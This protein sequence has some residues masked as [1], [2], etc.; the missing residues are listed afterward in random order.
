M[1]KWMRPTARRFI[2][3]MSDNVVTKGLGILFTKDFVN[4]AKKVLPEVAVVNDAVERAGAFRND[5]QSKAADI[6]KAFKAL[7]DADQKTVNAVLEQATVFG[8]WPMGPKGK[9]RKEY[10]DKLSDTDRTNAERVA[11][12]Y[13]SL[14]MEA[15]LVVDSVLHHGEE[16]KETMHEEIKRAGK[17]RHDEQMAR[18]YDPEKRKELEQTFKLQ[19][20]KVDKDFERMKGPYV[21]LKRFGR[22]VVT[23][24]SKAYREKAKFAEQVRDRLR[25]KYPNPTPAQLVPYHRLL[26]ELDAMR[27][28]SDDYIVET[29][30]TLGQA[31]ERARELQEL[32]PE[33]AVAAFAAAEHLNASVPSW[34]KLQQ[35]ALSVEHELESDPAQPGRAEAINQLYRAAN[36]MY[37]TALAN[38]SAKKAMLRRKTV[39]GWNSNMMENFKENARA[40]SSNLANLKYGSQLRSAITAMNE[41]VSAKTGSDKNAASEY[42]NEMIKRLRIMFRGEDSK[43]VSAVMRGTS[44]HML[45]TNPAYYLQNATQPFMMSAPMIAAKHGGKAFTDMAS[46]AAS[47]AKWLSKGASIDSLRTRLSK[48]EWKA[49]DKAR[50]AGHI[51]IGITQDFG[52]VSSENRSKPAKVLIAIGDK[53]TDI[54]RKAEILN[55]VATFLTA[56]R[57]EKAKTGDAE[58]AYNYADD[59]IY[60]T[61]GDYS[62]WNAPRYFRANDLTKLATQFRKFQL[63]QLGFFLRMAKD[64]FGSGS[65]EQKLLA[66]K[67]LGWTMGVHLTMAGLRG[68][69]AAAVLMGALGMAFGEDD[70][71]DEETLRRLVGNKALSDLL[72]GGVPAAL[73]VDLSEKIGAANMLDPFPYYEM[74]TSEGRSNYYELLGNL[75]GPSASLGARAADGLRYVGNGDYWKGMEQFLPTGLANMAKAARFGMDGITTRNGDVMIPDEDFSFLELAGVATGLPTRKV[76]DRNRLMDDLMRHEQNF[77]DQADRIRND[78]RKAVKDRDFKARK[79]AL[80]EWKE[81]NA[82]KRRMGFRPTP[83]SALYRSAR[84]QARRERNAIGGVGADRSNSAYL[85]RRSEM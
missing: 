20:R 54:A 51:D 5:W 47:L 79:A 35:V 21:P 59:V 56:Y 4:L 84:D 27:T 15:Q 66:R 40:E 67:A 12:L 2:D 26:K 71:D 78:Y 43:F 42:R 37:I 34:E 75:A 10:L 46:T 85:K 33:A 49:L 11:K 19:M 65:Q 60:Q 18:T 41:A 50:D 45:L 24:Y 64:S 57:L 58:A 36:E 61:H 16:A 69:P 77:D 22:F 80:D 28:N 17:L 70:E 14:P 8:V 81:M 31:N 25:Q 52:H 73:G 44:A 68:T 7:S 39:K 1:P 9:T 32:F 6:Y 72:M 48:D 83:I 3:T 55:R 29:Y 53:L 82:S 23:T 63:I 13:D 38:N 30:E 76:T 74:R 62:A